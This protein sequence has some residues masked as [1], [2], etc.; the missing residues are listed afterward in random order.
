MYH[1]EHLWAMKEADGSVRIGISDYAQDRL[2]SVIFVELPTVGA[3]LS[4]GESGAELESV[5]ATSEAIMPMSGTVVEVNKA[6][7]DTP[8][9]INSSPYGEGWLMRI[10]PAYP[11]EPGLISASEYA[12]LVGA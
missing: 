2:N 8:E 9:R 6:L 4:Q 7:D 10:T 12:A 1:K 11:D 5:K 3:Y